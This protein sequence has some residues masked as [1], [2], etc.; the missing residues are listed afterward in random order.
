MS[1]MLR[2]SVHSEPMNFDEYQRKAATTAIFPEDDALG[3]VALGVNGEAGEIA[4][5]VKKWKREDD[6]SYLDG[7]EKEIGDVTWYLSQLCEELG[8]SYD[9]VAVA[10]IEKLADRQKRNVLTGEGDN[11]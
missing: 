9:D 6:R 7:L 3:Y 8:L 2:G 1:H 11:R 10:N 4:E 5:K